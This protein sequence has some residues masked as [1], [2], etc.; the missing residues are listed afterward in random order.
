MD[1]I[2]G[3]GNLRRLKY[4]YI[5]MTAAENP[6]DIN[7]PGEAAAR[8]RGYRV[9]TRVH[10]VRVQVHPAAAQESAIGDKPDSAGRKLTREVAG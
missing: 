3:G 6:R 1:K 2:A 4:C 8:R 9:S 5:C 7:D 10:S